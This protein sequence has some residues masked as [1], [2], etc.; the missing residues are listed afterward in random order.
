MEK[1]PRERE[2]ASA[3]LRKAIT[4]KTRQAVGGP[5]RPPTSVHWV[6][7]RVGGVTGKAKKHHQEEGHTGQSGNYKRKGARVC[8]CYLFWPFKF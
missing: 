6:L 8:C 2:R 1:R 3:R 5:K 7:V 4:A